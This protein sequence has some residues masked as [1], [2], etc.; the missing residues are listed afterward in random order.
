MFTKKKVIFLKINNK[1]FPTELSEEIMK[2]YSMS[3]NEES[4]QCPS[5]LLAA[6][7]SQPTIP[8]EPAVQDELQSTR[9]FA[10]LNVTLKHAEPRLTVDSPSDP[11]LGF[12]SNLSISLGRGSFGAGVRSRQPPPVPQRPSSLIYPSSFVNRT[13]P[14]M[15]QPIISIF[16]YCVSNISCSRNQFSFI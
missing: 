12:Q 15:I 16:F 3:E 4:L 13:A 8:E 10:A 5:L 7:P 2:E 6:T 11:Q 9:G 1:L 14:G